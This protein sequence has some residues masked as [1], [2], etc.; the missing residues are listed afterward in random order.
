MFKK[1]V[2]TIVFIAAALSVMFTLSGCS[3]LKSG[4]REGV[5]DGISG[6]LNRGS[7]DSDS[8]SSSSNGGYSTGGSSLSSGSDRN[9]PERNF[10]GSSQNVPW[11]QDSTWA[12]YGL[13]G[14]R[15]PMGTDVTT[16]ALYMGYYMVNLINGGRSAFDSLA[17]QIDRMPN[18]QLITEV[19]D[20]GSM[21]VGYSTPEGM[22][23]IIADLESGD[24]AIQANQN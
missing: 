20:S 23:N 8:G 11:P 1:R 13:S 4:A 12:R 24:V 19:M 17:S 3:S 16:A 15:Q 14:L 10:S 18:T 6:L 2:I 9:A 21:M 7:S 5:M 22:V